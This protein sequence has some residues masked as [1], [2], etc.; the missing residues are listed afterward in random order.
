MAGIS[1]LIFFP[2][3][4]LRGFSMQQRFEEWLYLCYTDEKNEPYRSCL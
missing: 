3:E 4:F 2:A 1:Y